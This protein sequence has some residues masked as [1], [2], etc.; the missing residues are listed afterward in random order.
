[1]KSNRLSYPDSFSLSPLLCLLPNKGKVSR[2]DLYTPSL[3]A[4]Y[5]GVTAQY[6]EMIAS[7]AARED[8]KALAAEE[9]M[10]RT[11]LEWLA[12]KP[13]SGS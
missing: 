2:L 8:A 10:L 3:F 1:M 4:R 11:V 13:T 5:E 12:V 7:G 6:R 9:A